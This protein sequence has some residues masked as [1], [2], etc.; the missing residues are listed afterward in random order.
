MS[1][2]FPPSYSF[3]SSYGFPPSFGFSSSYR[4]P[5]SYG[6]SSSY[7]F[8][9]SHGFSSSYGFGSGSFGFSSPFDWPLSASY[10]WPF[11]EVEG[12]GEGRGLEA[13]GG[14]ELE[15][16]SAQKSLR[17]LYKPKSDVVDLLEA[18]NV[19]RSRRESHLR[20]L[21]GQPPRQGMMQ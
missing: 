5:P 12:G 3:S 21:R 14:S 16:E 20:R 2:G 13:A 17:R 18:L 10:A 7:A 1:Y 11:L 8:S 6:F 4:L 19:Q 15:T 9:S